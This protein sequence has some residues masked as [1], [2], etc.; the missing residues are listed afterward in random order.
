MECNDWS[1][2]SAV[3]QWQLQ[4]IFMTCHYDPAGRER[5]SGTLGKEQD[6]FL[7]VISIFYSFSM[8]A[9]SHSS[10]C[11]EGSVVGHPTSQRNGDL[12]RLKDLGRKGS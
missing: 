12:E 6:I 4:Q 2:K 7:G 5:G 11:E 1:F 10:P 3:W 9:V 8:A